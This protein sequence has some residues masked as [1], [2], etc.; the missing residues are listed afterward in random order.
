MTK[1]RWGVWGCCLLTILL[2]MPVALAPACTGDDDDDASDDD[3]VGDDDTDDDTSDDDTSDDDTSDDDTS[4]DDTSDDDDDDDTGPGRPYTPACAGASGPPSFAEPDLPADGEG[5]FAVGESEMTFTD[6]S[7]DREINTTIY[8][9]QPKSAAAGP[10]PVVVISHGFTS[11]RSTVVP[12]GERLATWGYIAI[13]PQLPYTNFLQIGKVNHTESAKD[14]LFLLN[15]ACAA[16]DESS[17]LFAGKVDKARLATLGH[18]LGGKLSILAALLD[19]GVAAVAG[20]DPVDGAG[21]I[22]SDDAE[23]F[24]DA[25]ERVADEMRIPS[26]YLGGTK[27]KEP[28]TGNQACAPEDD[29]YLTFYGAAPTPTEQITFI[30]ANHTDFISPIPL[31]PCNL[32]DADEETVMAR[33]MEYVTAF[34]NHRLLGFDDYAADYAGT[35]IDQDVTDGI[36]T[37]SVK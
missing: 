8:M 27:G 36:V 9:P 16:S 6:E 1:V 11:F 25:S 3:A 20:L 33:S 2:V 28:A 34:F 32:G 12:Y 24:P 21:P 30:G 14:I 35:G 19:E 37:Y 7:R 5:P 31:D 23:R 15:S 4:D 10:Y 22:D 13:V 17:G 18:S 29:N 26:L